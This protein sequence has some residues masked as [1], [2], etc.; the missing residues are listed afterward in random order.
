MRHQRSKNSIFIWGFIT[1]VLLTGLFAF[2][3]CQMLQPQTPSPTIDEQPLDRRIGVIRSLGGVKTSNQGTHLLQLDDGSS[4]LLK[5]LQVNMDDPQYAN[6]MVEVR[7]IMTYTTDSKQIMEVMNVD[8]LLNQSSQELQTPTWKDFSSTDLGFSLKYR[9]DLVLSDLHDGTVIFQRTIP[10]SDLSTQE[11]LSTQSAPL[12]HEFRIDHSSIPAGQTLIDAVK[13]NYYELKG[14]D[15]GALL[16]AGMMKSKVGSDSLDAIKKTDGSVTEYFVVSNG[17]LYTVTLHTGSDRQS[18]DD[19]NLFYEMLGTFRLGSPVVTATQET[20]VSNNSSSADV[21]T[22]SVSTVTDTKTP[23]TPSSTQA[24]L[25]K[26]ESLTTTQATVAPTPPPGIPKDITAIVVP[27][28]QQT[29]ATTPTDLAN[30]TQELLNGYSKLASDSFKFSVQY[31]KGWYYSGSAP[32]ETGVVRHYDFDNK[33]LEDQIGSVQF[34][35]MSGSVPAGSSVSVNGKTVTK[36]TNGDSVSFYSQGSGSHVYRIT[37]SATQES[38]LETI[39]STV[40]D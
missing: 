9:D 40:Q 20:D 7:G 37:G 14:T 25:P 5:S 22:T 36:V 3:G 11:T 32:T 12:S 23:V 21:S 1:A 15:S 27:S 18:L 34:D 38:T 30:Q 24:S 33:P 26:P 4:I 19:Q 35:I 8:I 10:A 29:L 17:S 31:P 39:I 16:A 6:K 2:Y 13:A 28:T